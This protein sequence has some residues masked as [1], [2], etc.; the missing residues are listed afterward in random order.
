MG[1]EHMALAMWKTGMRDEAYRI[2]KGNLLDSMNRGLCPGDFHMTSALN[3]HRQEA[4]RGFGDPIDI[5]S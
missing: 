1:S 4:Q 5:S 3:V 2:F